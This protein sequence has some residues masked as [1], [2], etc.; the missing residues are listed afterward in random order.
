MP[1]KNVKFTDG[2]SE[3]DEVVREFHKL[4]SESKAGEGGELF[5]NWN[6]ID[7]GFLDRC[8]IPSKRDDDD[9]E[10]GS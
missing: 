3:Y 9:L 10:D 5:D 1:V 7:P 4:M 6:E 2:D 8:S